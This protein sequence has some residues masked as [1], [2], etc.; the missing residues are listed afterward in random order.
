MLYPVLYLFAR[1]ADL[2]RFREIVVPLLFVLLP[3]MAAWLLLR[4]FVRDPHKAALLVSLAVLFFFSYGHVKNAV[5]AL[6]PGDIVLGRNRYLFPLLGVMFLAVVYV[7]VRTRRAVSRLTP[8]LNVAAVIL[9]GLSVVQIG[10]ARLARKA[11]PEAG[12]VRLSPPSD[13]QAV[14]DIYY[15]ILDGYAGEDVLAETFNYDNS[16]F[17]RQ[18]EQRGFFVSRSSR[19]NYCRTLLSLASSLNLTY[20]DS[21]AG[22]DASD[23]SPLLRMIWSSRLARSLRLAGYKSVVF[24]S[25]LPT[26]E[27]A[28]AE[29]YVAPRWSPGQLGNALLNITPIPG[30]LALASPALSSLQYDWHRRSLLYTFDH[31]GDWA[32]SDEPVFVF[33]HILA[34]HPPFVFGADGRAVSADRMFFYHDGDD[35]LR[36]GGTYEEYLL[37]YP[38]QLEYVNALTLAAIDTILARSVRPPIIVLQADHGARIRPDSLD[39]NP[40]YHRRLFSILNALYVPDP[41]LRL[42]RDD[43][44]PVNNFRVIF[45]RYFGTELPLLPDRC[46]YSSW[47]GLYDFVDVTRDA[48]PVNAGP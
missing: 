9:V 47:E 39:F 20:L 29:V 31:L 10:Y 40:A 19:S 11:V 33:A 3:A 16:E 4:L 13:P 25:P 1:N 17:Y 42:L 34:P 23:R 7:V 36:L 14:P 12:I 38:S 8:L 41:C 46:Y 32:R 15:L 18:L 2:F 43:L 37:D 30:L 6:T 35:F 28:A 44:S 22:W 24:A 48:R 45:D 26:T 21:L 27:R 5:L